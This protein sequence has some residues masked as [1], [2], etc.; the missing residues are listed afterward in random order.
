MAQLA[1]GRDSA[2]E[3]QEGGAASTATASMD[4]GNRAAGKAVPKVTPC[5][6]TYITSKTN[7]GFSTKHPIWRPKK[8]TGTRSYT[9]ASRTSKVKRSVAPWPHSLLLNLPPEASGRWGDTFGGLL[10]TF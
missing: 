6:S 3:E 4:P 9:Q 1:R 8:K 5:E 7:T 10:G 2:R